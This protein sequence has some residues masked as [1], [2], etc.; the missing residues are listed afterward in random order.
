MADFTHTHTL[1]V[2]LDSGVNRRVG[3]AL[4]GSGDKNADIFDLYLYK[5]QEG[6]GFEATACT[7]YFVRP[8]G[9][10]VIIEGEVTDNLA[11]VTLPAACYVYPGTFKLTIKVADSDT[12]VTAAVIDGRVI[13]TMTDDVADPDDVWSLSAMQADIDSKLDAPAAQG[14]SGQALLADGQGGAYWGN[15]SSSQ[16]VGSVIVNNVTYQ[17][18]TGTEGAAGYLTLVEES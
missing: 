14:S 7:G 9:A 11:S 13:E 2:E 5:S 12:E 8:D 17:L 15:P 1:K 18:R 6:A 3:G 10:T 16:A 4:L